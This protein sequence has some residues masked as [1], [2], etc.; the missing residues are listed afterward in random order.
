MKLQYS[1]ILIFTGL[2]ALLLL[3][4]NLVMY[5]MSS[6]Y[7]EHGFY[8]S[9]ENSA[10]IVASA[11]L[12]QEKAEDFYAIKNNILQHLEEEEE[13]IMRIKPGS[14][15]VQFPASLP[16]DESFY[17]QAINTGRARRRYR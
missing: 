3:G 1:L 13:Y 6:G 14:K 8:I 4:I 15:D 12:Q 5:S 17:W 11:V 9:M 7:R 10:S 2:M 16:L